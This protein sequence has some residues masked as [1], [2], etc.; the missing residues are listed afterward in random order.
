[1]STTEHRRWLS[2]EEAA[3]HTGTDSDWIKAHIKNGALKV[4]VTANRK[5]LEGTGPRRFKIDRLKLDALM[6]RLEV[7]ATPKGPIEAET[8]KPKPGPATMGRK[9]LKERLAEGY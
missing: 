2:V 3:E 1:M 4:V 8:P 9:S 6:E 5:S 7:Y